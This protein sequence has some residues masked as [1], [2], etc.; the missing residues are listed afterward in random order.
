[1]LNI[2]LSIFVPFLLSLFLT[3]L[4]MVIAKKKNIVDMPNVRKS[5]N[6]PIPLL[7]GVAIL[8]AV[9]LSIAAFAS[10]T[11]VLIKI[12]LIGAIIGV[13]LIG[14]IDDI[15]ALSAKR[16]L[17]VLIIQALIVYLGCIQFYTIAHINTLFMEIV[18]GAF[19]VL[20][21]VAVT[22][23]VNFSDGLDGLSSYLTIIASISFAILFALQERTVFSLPI[24]LSVSG[25]VAGFLTYNRNPAMIFMGDAGSM[26]LGFVLGLLSI[27]STAKE[28]TIL[29][30]VVPI[31]ILLVPIADMLT[32]ILRRIIIRRPVMKPDKMHFHHVLNEK[33]N[34]HL[35]VAIVL[36]LFQIVC[37]AFGILVFVFKIYLTGFIVLAAIFIILIIFT[38]ITSLTIRK[39]QEQNHDAP[40]IS[41]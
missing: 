26:L 10:Y 11:S 31:F 37:A 9:T 1:M 14:L 6:K 8:I 12:T 30:L 25:A 41:D 28:D 17:F 19:V 21:I 3:P 2:I 35:F 20:W 33:I 29:S 36:S 4:M 13:S 15:I 16:R 40:P 39:R 32:S 7:G 22:N 34:N 18:F 27:V 5:H 23:A 24:A 38:I